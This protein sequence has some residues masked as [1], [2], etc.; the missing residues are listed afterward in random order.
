MSDKWQPNVKAMEQVDVNDPSFPW[1]N[2]KPDWDYYRLI[3]AAEREE[4]YKNKNIS[5][6]RSIAVLSTTKDLV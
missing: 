5:H 1:R 2:G 6:S 4:K 3:K